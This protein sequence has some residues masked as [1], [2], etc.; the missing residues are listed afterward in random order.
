[1]KRF[2]WN[3]DTMNQYCCE[4]NTGYY[5]LETKKVEKSYQV[6]LWA[7]VKCPRDNHEPYWVWWNN[8]LKGY[9]CKKCYHE[10]FEIT[11][12]N[13]KKVE[14]FY[15]EYGLKVVED[16]SKWKSVDSSI[17][18]IDD[19]GYK[20]TTS[21]TGLRQYGKSSFK[22]YRLNKYSLENI[23][24]YCKRNRPDYDIVSD[25]YH[26]I[27]KEYTWIYKGD[28][29]EG[30]DNK[31]VMIA[32]SFI[33]GGCGHPYFGTS[34]GEMIFENA[35]KDNEIEFSREKKFEECRDKSIL[36]FDFHISKPNIL[37]E[38][39]GIQHDE[40][41]EFWGGLEGYLDRKHKDH[42]KD[43][44]CE[45]NHIEL[46]RIKYKTNELEEYNMNVE[47]T[48]KILKDKIV[49]IDNV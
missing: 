41:I 42:I 24:N 35:L 26:G 8:F 20:Y 19:E 10:E 29:P 38:I 15:K 34:N 13:T 11:A 7:L 44:F 1:M 22:F 27:K 23:K 17:L 31:F 36:F 40:I 21:I 30:I 9:W 49:L 14:S 37:V 32:D 28:L 12:W 18:T 45:E 47:S 2:G 5:V 25:K 48:L 6:Q 3:V 43:V 4:N 33:N 39:D 16:I 46:I